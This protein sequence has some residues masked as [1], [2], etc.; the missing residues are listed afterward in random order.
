M[1]LNK[2]RW[3]EPARCRNALEVELTVLADRLDVGVKYVKGIV[4]NAA[5]KNSS[6]NN[7]ADGE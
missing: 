3:T 5:V 2:Y 1:N 7:E 6:L 4:R